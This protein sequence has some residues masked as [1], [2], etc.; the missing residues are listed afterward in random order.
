MRIKDEGE[1]R[2]VLLLHNRIELLAR[3]CLARSMSHALAAHTLSCQDALAAYD[4]DR[5]GRLNLKEFVTML[6][7]VGACVPGQGALGLVVTSAVIGCCDRLDSLDFHA[8]TDLAATGAVGQKDE[9][10]EVDD[11]ATIW[12]VSPGLPLASAS[13]HAD[14]LTAPLRAAVSA[15]LLAVDEGDKVLENLET[16]AA[17]DAEAKAEEVIELDEFGWRVYKGDPEA[18]YR[19]GAGVHV[20]DL[21][22]G[23]LPETLELV[24]DVEMRTFVDGTAYLHVGAYS[25]FAIP[26]IGAK[27]KRGGT[28]A[29]LGRLIVPANTR[30]YHNYTPK[31]APSI[32]DVWVAREAARRAYLLLCSD[33]PVRVHFAGV[34][35]AE[36]EDVV[37]YDHDLEVCAPVDDATLEASLSA[38]CAPALG[39]ECWAEYVRVRDQHLKAAS[40]AG[41]KRGKVGGN[42]DPSEH[43]SPH[44]R[45]FFGTHMAST[46]PLGAHMRYSSVSFS[47]GRVNDYRCQIIKETANVPSDVS[48][49]REHHLGPWL[50][51][52]ASWDD[53]K[54][55]I[56]TSQGNHEISAIYCDFNRKVSFLMTSE[57][58]YCATP[59]QVRYALVSSTKIPTKQTTLLLHVLGCV[60]PWVCDA[61]GVANAEDG[62][63]VVQ[64][65]ACGW[66]REEAA[67]LEGD[68]VC[69]KCVRSRTTKQ[70]TMASG[71][72]VCGECE[73]ELL[74]G[75]ALE[76]WRA[77]TVEA[78]R[79]QCRAHREAKG[80][81]CGAEAEVTM[82][83]EA[84][85]KVG[86]A[87]DLVDA[88]VAR[89]RALVVKAKS[90]FVK[91]VWAAMQ[92]GAD[93][94]DKASPEV[95]LDQFAWLEEYGLRT[96][97]G[98][99]NKGGD[100]D[101]GQ[102][103]G[104][105]EGEVVM[106]ADEDED[107]DDQEEEEEDDDEQ[108]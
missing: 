85:A 36:L 3:A 54:C 69:D 27:K 64:C 50:P 71:A 21:T 16:G 28:V 97:L 42:V 61:C 59:A 77:Q 73:T 65:G 37:L 106:N 8:L 24:G 108:E 20:L 25:G 100:D 40:G 2:Q 31:E 35:G 49:V 60:H 4:S 86:D 58:D 55:E 70:R 104:E 102:T 80:V 82:T 9:E 96:V 5:D 7:S 17:R 11:T 6:L 101:D 46:H 32:R 67:V 18:L 75:A 52:V 12:T 103:E 95:G 26:P 1:S 15:R 22:L 19:A 89:R 57:Y 53:N 107:E 105:V 91:R 92:G 83:P 94:N 72:A 74:T 43:A 98:V 79:R 81:L 90:A 78:R 10:E 39:R 14:A 38:S 99:Q 66:V 30:R 51:Y 47:N 56:S 44:A 76:E 34:C 88:M 84:R 68:D 29:M 23:V 45:M 48:E 93:K 13:A 63:A 62:G 87:H 33:S 41:G